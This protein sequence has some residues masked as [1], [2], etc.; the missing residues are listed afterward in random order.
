MHLY[1]EDMGLDG[2]LSTHAGSFV[3][4]FPSFFTAALHSADKRHTL[5][6]V[7]RILWRWSISALVYCVQLLSLLPARVLRLL[8]FMGFGGDGDLGR[9]LLLDVCACNNSCRRFV[10]WRIGRLV[11]RSCLAMSRCLSRVRCGR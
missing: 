1:W 5:T 2:L 3:H 9:A 8:E 11:E 10:Q 6:V 4:A 7:Q